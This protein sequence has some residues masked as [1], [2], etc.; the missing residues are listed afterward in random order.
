MCYVTAI[1]TFAYYAMLSG[2]GWLITPNCRQLFYVRSVECQH[3]HTCSECLFVTD[4]STG[5]SRHL[6]SFWIWVWS[7]VQILVW[8]LLW[9]NVSFLGVFLMKETDYRSG[10]AYDLRWIHGFYFFW[11]HQMALVLSF[12]VDFRS[13]GLRKWR[14]T[15]HWCLHVCILTCII[16]NAKGISNFGR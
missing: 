10:Y 13:S 5:S 8:T 16:D 1:S 14:S 12:A 6:W 11:A 2:Q 15:A 4:T 9:V 7:S 3:M